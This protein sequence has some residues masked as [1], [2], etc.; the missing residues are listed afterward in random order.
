MKSCHEFLISLY[1]RGAT[2]WIE[3]NQLKVQAPKGSISLD[4]QKQLREW[5]SEMMAILKSWQGGALLIPIRPR[6]ANCLVPLTLGQLSEWNESQRLGGMSWRACVAGMEI[7][8]PLN[9]AILEECVHILIARHE[10][11]RTCIVVVDG[12]LQQRIDNAV[13]SNLGFTD[14]SGSEMN[15]LNERLAVQVEGF[16]GERI[17][18]TVGPV[19]SARLYRLG[20]Q[21]HVFVVALHH[22]VG[23]GVSIRI[24]CDE[25]CD[26]YDQIS[27]GVSPS[28]QTKVV[29]F[30]D[31]VVWQ[32]SIYSCWKA[33]HG[34]YWK[35][36][37]KEA[38]PIQ[39][40]YGSDKSHISV[41][42]LLD[43][44]FGDELSTKLCGLAAAEHVPLSI[45]ML[46]IYVIVMSSWLDRIDLIVTVITNNRYRPEL[47]KMIGCIAG[48]VLLR[49]FVNRDDNF[50]EL[51]AKVNV[52]FQNAYNHLFIGSVRLSDLGVGAD[53]NA[54]VV[55]NWDTIRDRERQV[56]DG[57]TVVPYRVN[58][59]NDTEFSLS[60]QEAQEGIVATVLHQ[61]SVFPPGMIMNLL[62]GLVETARQCENRPLLALREFDVQGLCQQSA[63]GAVE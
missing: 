16:L 58:R 11:L 28:H 17:D 46:A 31:Y 21:E 24:V 57:I 52:E 56:G 41:A 14:L 63:R 45:L 26:L 2:L 62:E 4:E 1:Q 37:L 39:L 10:S 47:E 44:H 12:V 29:Q 50:H 48:A 34:E 23:D 18:L 43:I 5:K 7:A 38:P 9:V 33:E 35:G 22:V 54:C 40:P 60:F 3:H 8:G 51:L 15:V 53:L 61:P 19:F 6:P 30:A 20:C 27:H 55:F 32:H 59:H 25:I 36:K 49:V 42:K 13:T